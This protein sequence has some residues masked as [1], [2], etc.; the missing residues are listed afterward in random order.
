MDVTTSTSL[1][2]T[3]PCPL[4]SD[5]FRRLARAMRVPAQ[6]IDDVVQQA[7]LRI[8]ENR[9]RVGLARDAAAYADQIVR[10][11]ARTS[12]RRARRREEVIAPLQDEEPSDERPGPEASVIARQR[13]FVLWRF[14]D[15][16][17]D[18]RRTV[19]IEHELL[20]RTLA[21]IALAHALSENTVK[22]RL[23]AAWDSVEQE[24][25]RWQA[26][27]RWRGQATVPCLVPF[28][29]GTWLHD[30]LRGLGRFKLHGAAAAALVLGAGAAWPGPAAGSAEAPLLAAS[31]RA[32]PAI[33]IP[34]GPADARGVGPGGPESAIGRE[35][36]TASV[37][38]APQ[39]SSTT[40][41]AA[42]AAAERSSRGGTGAEHARIDPR[43]ERARAMLELGTT[44][45]QLSA[46]RLLHEHRERRGRGEHAA[47]RDALL[48]RVRCERHG[49]L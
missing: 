15:K 45:G 3:A 19:F 12:R 38:S 10:N 39:G 14:I 16:L 34:A 30:A 28:F 1:D 46:C 4:G 35:A 48:R 11:E 24:R 17:D 26:E 20:G 43:L 49:S 32:Q 36:V 5:R 7:W 29:S 23:T 22:S 47:E 42:S 40:A 27:Q 44:E 9:A 2:V 37:V 33:E 21:E 6:D 8:L 25:A 13:A 18:A 31:G 41:R